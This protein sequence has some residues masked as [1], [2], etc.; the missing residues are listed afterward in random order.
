MTGMK[1]PLRLK[2]MHLV[3]FLGGRPRLDRR[4]DLTAQGVTKMKDQDI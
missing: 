4:L 3:S 2:G 1:G